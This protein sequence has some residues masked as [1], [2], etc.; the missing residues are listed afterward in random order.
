MTQPGSKLLG[1]ILL[2]LK[3][4]SLFSESTLSL[5]TG[6]PAAIEAAKIG[7]TRI[8]AICRVQQW[9]KVSVATVSKSR[10]GNFLYDH[11][12]IRA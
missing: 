11:K 2:R 3:I 5:R 4:E 10:G 8:E 9:K 1:L 6:V 7:K 12:E